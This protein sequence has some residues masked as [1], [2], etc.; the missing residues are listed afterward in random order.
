VACCLFPIQKQTIENYGIVAKPVLAL[1]LH[2]ERTAMPLP[3]LG[4]HHVTSKSSDPRGTDRFWREAVG[5]RRIKQTV[6]FDNPSVYHLYYG[7]EAADPG[8]VMTYFPFPGLSRGSRGAGEVGS[9]AFRVAKGSL[10]LWEARLEAAGAGEI[11]RDTWFGE[12][13]LGFEAPDG[14][15]FRLI[16]N[17]K[18]GGGAVTGFHS[19][20][21]T[22]Q[23]TA[24]TATILAAFGYR[25]EAVEGAVTR[26]RLVRG[27]GAD[28]IDLEAAPDLPKAVEGAGSVHHI[29]FAVRDR[30]AQ[31]EVREAMLDMGQRVTHI[32]D[33]D[34]FH[35]IYF[36][37][38]G[39]VLFE[40]ATCAPGFAVDEDRAHLGESLRL[41]KQHE[42]R[43]AELFETLVPLD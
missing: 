13:G 19:A 1:G 2:N 4:L 33:R 30:A 21:L 27:N 25:Q 29:A 41:P 8:T 7:N 35:A 32:Y 15:R 26:F 14:D 12:D 20:R 16:A 22:L 18:G 24:A 9:V 3:I 23:D 38:D 11:F 31:D 40:V 34:Y 37:T 43:R 5:L 17:A 28:V 42:H 36:R 10:D 6:N 39:G